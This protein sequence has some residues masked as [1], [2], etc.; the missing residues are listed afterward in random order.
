M[1]RKYTRK[2][3]TFK[4]NPDFPEQELFFFSWKT[5]S[6]NAG[7]LLI[8]KFGKMLSKIEDLL[9]VEYLRA[10][11]ILRLNLGTNTARMWDIF[12]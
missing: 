11:N 10:A 7:K 5:K 3:L 9:C 2:F 8:S 1:C 12:C 4:T 6:K